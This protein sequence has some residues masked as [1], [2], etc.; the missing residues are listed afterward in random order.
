[1]TNRYKIIYFRICLR[2]RYTFKYW[3]LVGISSPTPNVRMDL[4]NRELREHSLQCPY[5]TDHFITQ[6]SWAVQLIVGSTDES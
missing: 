4:G 5:P 6:T 2:V 3:H 1:M